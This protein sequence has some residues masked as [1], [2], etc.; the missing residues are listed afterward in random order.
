MKTENELLRIQLA[1]LGEIKEQISE[2]KSL[3]AE[4]NEQIKILK[5]SNNSGEI[6]FSSINIEVDNEM[7]TFKYFLLLISQLNL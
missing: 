3:K 7:K 4:L 6:K 2:I 1:D 5:A